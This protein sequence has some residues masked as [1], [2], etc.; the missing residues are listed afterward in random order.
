MLYPMPKMVRSFLRNCK[1]VRIELASYLLSYSS[2]SLLQITCCLPIGPL[3]E[4]PLTCSEAKL[5]VISFQA[6]FPQLA[7]TT[8]HLEG[9]L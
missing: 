3:V 6:N 2:C 7:L 9:K 8:D 4:A 5:L 1:F